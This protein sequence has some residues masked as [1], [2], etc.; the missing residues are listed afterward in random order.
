M[1]SYREVYKMCKSANDFYGMTGNDANY[2]IMN[3]LVQHEDQQ[4]RKQEER[5]PKAQLVKAQ[6]S[7]GEPRRAQHTVLDAVLTENYLKNR[8]SATPNYFGRMVNPMS[9]QQDY[10]EGLPTMRAR[11]AARN[12]QRMGLKP[13]TK[14]YQTMRKALISAGEINFKNYINK[15]FGGKGQKTI[16]ELD[17]SI[18]DPKLRKDYQMTVPHMVQ[19]AVKGNKYFIS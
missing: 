4:A 7:R 11:Q 2:N 9:A 8:W 13:G 16:P 3:K 5:Q 19:N 14:D 1:K 17:K 18:K 6:L 15:F 12:A 10:I